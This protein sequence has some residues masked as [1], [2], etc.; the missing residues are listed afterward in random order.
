[1]FY[2]INDVNPIG[3]GTISKRTTPEKKMYSI[4]Q[5]GSLRT[6]PSLIF[7]SST[8]CTNPNWVFEEQTHIPFSKYIMATLV[9][10][11]DV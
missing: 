6:F 11:Q 9:P 8:T 10:V 5:E 2:R 3:T 1:M 4:I 7:L